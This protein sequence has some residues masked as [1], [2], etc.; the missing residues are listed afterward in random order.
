[1][2][3]NPL[4]RS[5]S[6]ERKAQWLQKDLEKDT[7]NEIAKGFIRGYKHL[8]EPSVFKDAIMNDEK[9][10]SL[11]LGQIHYKT[12]PINETF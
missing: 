4:I 11:V 12:L 10:L 3:P 6:Y 5:N 7:H 9:I 2:G 8:I 1:M